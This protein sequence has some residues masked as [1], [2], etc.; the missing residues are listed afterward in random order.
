MNIESNDSKWI[1]QKIEQLIVL[2]NNSIWESKF[3]L[4]E[5]KQTGDV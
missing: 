5:E 4:V 1:N 3:D 2:K